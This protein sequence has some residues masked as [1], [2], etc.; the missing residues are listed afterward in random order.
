MRLNRSALS[1]LAASTILAQGCAS[2]PHTSAEIAIGANVTKNAPW[3]N[4]RSGGFDG[5]TDTI[6]FTVRQEIGQ[7]TFCAY[8]HVSHLSA[9]WPVN[10][11]AEDWLDTIECG[12]R[13]G[14]K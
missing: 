9:G 8:N 13:F 12:V 10:D 6:R 4:G 5:P 11:R 1:L 14:R 3:S 7:N 2:L